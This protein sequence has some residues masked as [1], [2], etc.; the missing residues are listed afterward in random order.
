MSFRKAGSLPTCRRSGL[1]WSNRERRKEGVKFLEADFLP[2]ASK[3][4]GAIK[5]EI[6]NVRVWSKSHGERLAR[7]IQAG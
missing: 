7:R 5:Q 1:F 6:E 3:A 4:V 2:F